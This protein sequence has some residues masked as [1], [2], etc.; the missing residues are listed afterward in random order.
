MHANLQHLLVLGERLL[1]LQI[2]GEI[3]LIDCSPFAKALKL[4]LPGWLGP[5][6]L[7]RVGKVGPSLP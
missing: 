6:Q 4:G 5:P 3:L 1:I 2:L 7:S